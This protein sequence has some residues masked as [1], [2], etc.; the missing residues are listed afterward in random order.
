MT[1]DEVLAQARIGG[2]ALVGGKWRRIVEIKGE[3]V[4]LICVETPNNPRYWPMTDRIAAIRLPDPAR[5]PDAVEHVGADP[6]QDG[7][8][9]TVSDEVQAPSLFDLAE[10][11][12]KWP[13]ASG[14][15]YEFMLAARLLLTKRDAA[16]DFI[17]DGGAR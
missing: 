2:M 1:R 11:V 4:R 16:L 14:D 10:Q 15:L 9:L 6:V 3:R 8:A 13:N 17:R 7:P 12:A 5:K